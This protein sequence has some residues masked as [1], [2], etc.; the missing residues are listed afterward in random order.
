MDWRHGSEDWVAEDRRLRAEEADEAWLEEHGWACEV[1][2]CN[3]IGHDEDELDKHYADS[4][5]GEDDRHVD[6]YEG[7]RAAAMEMHKKT[8]RQVMG[9]AFDVHEQNRVE[10]HMF[11]E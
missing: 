3:F 9:D 11:G 10:R 6:E 4:M 7:E 8:Y 1:K 2:E 5:H